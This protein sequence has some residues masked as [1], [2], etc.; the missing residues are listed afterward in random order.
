MGKNDGRNEIV[1]QYSSLKRR[2]LIAFSGVLAVLS[3][4]L[5]YQGTN[6]FD[7]LNTSLNSSKLSIYWFQVF[8]GNWPGRVEKIEDVGLGKYGFSISAFLA[9]I[10]NYAT[11]IGII[12][13][14]WQVLPLRRRE[15]VML[16]STSIHTRDR[17]IKNSLEVSLLDIVPEKDKKSIVE[18]VNAS[19]REG[20]DAWLNDYMPEILGDT[21][22]EELR[23][24]LGYE[25]GG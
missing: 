16:V 17:L 9:L 10:L 24:T 4:N 1:H 7:V 11:I 15:K 23:K 19:F 6:V 20:N 14:L 18:I 2:V 22:V 12:G 25:I 3:I 5:L 8:S 13:V 21:G